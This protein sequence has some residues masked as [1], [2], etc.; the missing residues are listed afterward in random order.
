MV[1][2][3]GIAGRIAGILCATGA[4]L[5]A[6]GLVDPSARPLLAL[7]NAL[8]WVVLLVYAIV[9]AIVRPRAE[10]SPG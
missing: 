6:F 10:P 8:S 4:A 3:G 9:A 5:G 2:R 7:G 1:A